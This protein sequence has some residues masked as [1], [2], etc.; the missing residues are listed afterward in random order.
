MKIKLIK[1]LDYCLGKPFC[2]FFSILKTDVSKKSDLKKLLIIRPGG[3]GDAV[4]LYPSLKILRKSF[5]KVQIDILAEKM[6]AGVFKGCKYIDNLYLYDDFMNL[7]LYK[8]LIAGYDAVIDTEQW[9][10]LTAVIGFLARADIR[11]GF[12]TNERKKL[13]TNPVDYSQ[14]DYEAIS[15]LNLISEIT[16]ENHKFFK[17]KPFDL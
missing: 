6:N 8:V 14:D 13:L 7:S 17:N 15:F 9:H 3:I 11:V 4:L 12:A 16:G 1:F 5:E 2:Y 10:R